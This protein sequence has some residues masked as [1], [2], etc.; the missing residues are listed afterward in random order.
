MIHHFAVTESDF[1]SHFLIEKGY[2]A[3]DLAY[4]YEFGAIYVDGL[5]FRSD[6]QLNPNQIVRLHTKPKR[7]Q[8]E[9]SLKELIVERTEDWLVLDK[10]SGCPVHPTLDNY[11]ENA[12]TALERELGIPLFSTHR[13]DI[14]T[15]GLLIFALNKLAQRQINQAFAKHQVTKIYHAITD[16]P[17]SQGPH[18]LYLNPESRVPR[19]HSVEAHDSWWR[20]EMVIEESAERDGRF[21]HR[22]RLLTGKTHQ[23]RAQLAALGAPICGDEIYGSK[24]VHERLA[25]ECYSLSFA[26]RSR[27]LAWTRARTIAVP[28]GS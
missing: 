4:W 28:P 12:K 23:I 14:P 25:L 2:T 11:V 18:V 8:W 19:E 9:G 3:E 21:C 16:Q 20:C 13:L 10:P 5:R 7:Y 15:S 26:F 17:V 1:L 6:T 27:T 22:I 24:Y